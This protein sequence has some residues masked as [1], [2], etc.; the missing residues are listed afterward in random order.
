MAR[1]KIDYAFKS[2]VLKSDI[3]KLANQI[4]MAIYAKEL[5][6]E[7]GQVLQTQMD[8]DTALKMRCF[9]LEN[10]YKEYIEAEKINKARYLRTKRLRLKISNILK[11]CNTCIFLTLTFNDKILENTT[12]KTRRE[13]VKKYLETSG[14]P[15]VANIDFGSKNGREHYH[16]VVGDFVSLE[17]WDKKCGYALAEYIQIEKSLDFKKVP[18]RYQNLSPEEQ[19]TLMMADNEKK[20]SK[21]ISKLTNHAIKE[22]TKQSRAIYSSTTRGRK[23]DHQTISLVVDKSGQYK[24]QI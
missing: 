12:A 16:A 9:L 20:L 23:K 10:H 19:K 17:K 22:T 14:A 1:K 4:S 8:Y 7:T 2:K 21:Y 18:K 24:V 11:E 3:P 5:L 15:Y 13:Y 6:E